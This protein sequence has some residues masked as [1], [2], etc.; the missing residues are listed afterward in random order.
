MPDQ[1]PAERAASDVLTGAIQGREE[2]RDAV[3]RIQQAIDEATA[4]LRAAIAKFLDADGHDLCHDNRQYLALAIGRPND[5]QRGL[6]PEQE[7]A[8]RCIQYRQDLYGHQGPGSDAEI[9]EAR[10]QELKNCLTKVQDELTNVQPHIPQACYPGREK[11]I[12]A[13]LDVA[14]EAIEKVL[15]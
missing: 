3:H 8:E 14:R 1:T 13:H 9:Y 2:Y 15:R 10:I 11:F 6:P 7:F 12:D 4:E 5:L